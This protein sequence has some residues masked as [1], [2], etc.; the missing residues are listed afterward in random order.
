MILWTLLWS[1]SRIHKLLKCSK[2]P[3]KAENFPAIFWSGDK[4]SGDTYDPEDMCNGLFQGYV[5]VWVHFC[6]HSSHDS[7]WLWLGS[8]HTT[9]LSRTD[10]HSEYGFEEGYKV[11]QRVPA[12]HDNCRTWTHCLCLCPGK[13]ACVTAG[14]SLLVVFQTHFGISSMSSWS[15]KDGEFSYC[16][17]YC[18]VVSF[19]CNAVDIDWRDDLLKWWNLYI[20]YCSWCFAERIPFW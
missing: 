4:Y 8:D 7:E 20:D 3:M 18:L 13:L 12:W 14:K 16:E 2:I 9:Y 6:F 11:I 15:E 17:L 19:I 5:L 10:F 1:R